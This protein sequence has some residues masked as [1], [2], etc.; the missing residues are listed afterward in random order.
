MPVPPVEY[1]FTIVDGPMVTWQ[2]RSLHFYEALSEPYVLNLTIVTDDLGAGAE[3]LLGCSS[4]LTIDRQTV[5]RT[6]HGV[7]RAVESLGMDANRL[8]LRLEIVPALRLLDQR[9]DTRSWQAATVPE[10]VEEV[11]AA[12]LVDYDRA[13]ELDGL[14]RTY[15]PRQT[16]V[17]YHESDL[18]FVSRLLEEEGISYRFDHER[19]SGEV[20]ILE[21]SNA[22][23]VEVVTID[24]NSVLFVDSDNPEL[25]S[26]E[27]VQ[28][29]KSL[30]ELTPTAVYQRVFD[31][32]T[33]TTP[34]ESAA[35]ANGKADQDDFGRRRE[36]YHH[37]RFV[38]PDPGPRTLRK[39]GWRTQLDKMIGGVSNVTGI[40]PGRRF[41]VFDIEHAELAG[42]LLIRRAIHTGDCPEVVLESPGIAPRYQ[43][44]FECL[45][46]VPEQPV[47]PQIRT[48]QPRV[49]GPQTAIVTGPPGEEIH[50]DE[51]GRVKVRFDWDRKLNLDDDTSMWIRVAHNW[52]GPG[53]GTFFVPRIGMEV[54][55]EFLE[56]RP[57]QPLIVGCIYNGDNAISVG[58]PENKTQSTIR[59]SSSPGGGGYN[60]LRFE[61]GAGCE[62][63]YLHAQKNLNEV[64]GYCHS[65]SVMANQSNTVGANQTQTIGAAQ[66]ET[67]GAAQTLSVGAD[68]CKTVR[69]DETNILLAKRTTTVA[70]DETL[71][72]SGKSTVT[73][74][75]LYSLT[76]LA[77]FEQTVVGKNSLRVTAGESGS[78]QGSICVDDKF[79]LTACNRVALLQ[80]EDAQM[81]IEGGVVTHTTNNTFD[82]HA[83]GNL[84]LESGAVLSAGAME[85][86][87]LTQGSGKLD[88]SCNMVRVEA[89]GITLTVGDSTITI[90]KDTVEIKSSG[91]VS[92]K[93]SV[94]NLNC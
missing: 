76:G 79:E 40:I 71:T 25:A 92:V 94:V 75:G 7:V 91:P 64:V 59:T 58:V 20:L 9:V 54:V 11:L 66:T 18:D 61:D 62:E 12:A 73:S 3:I 65:T 13:V 89:E 63:I 87:V 82:I 26:V 42:E 86:V 14:T 53:F 22:A 83:V 17:Q 36:I 38:E 57:D 47:L 72:V 19:G 10:V 37:G 78:G 27:T 45:V 4:E 31:W 50:T 21:D 68:R 52:A 2:V 51:Y 74:Q 34:I 55:V 15:M 41:S 81:T 39:L 33:P 85:Q 30:R 44:H 5:S 46:Y 77:S 8:H 28:E 29:I 6:I 23:V 16:I 88:M 80:G 32:M 70:C 67:V 69:G 49:H 35:P 90:S 43:N 56:G 48:P 60:E 24:E 84:G 93:G 1:T